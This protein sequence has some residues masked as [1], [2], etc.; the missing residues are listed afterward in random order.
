MSASETENGTDAAADERC[1]SCGIT[2]GDDVK[3]KNCNA[4]KLVKY[5][6][7]KCQ[8]DHRS[9]H[10]RACKK[11]AAEL[12]D[13]LLFKQPES[14]HLGDCPICVLPLP[15]LKAGVSYHMMACC[16]KLV[17][18]GC[19]Y[20]NG[21]REKRER[22]L[23]T[24]PFC[25]HQMPETVEKNLLLEM[26]RLKSNENDPIAL[27]KMGMRHFVAGDHA[28]AIECWEK[29]VGSGDIQSHYYLSDVYYCHN[30]RGVEQDMKK[31]MYHA[32]QAAIGGHPAARHNLGTWEEDIGKA[33]KHFIIAANLG[34]DDSL[35]EL[36]CFL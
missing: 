28:A 1:A 32:E 29:A 14:T 23:P 26:K 10:K 27:N 35:Q 19:M 8:R 5:C 12:K 33:A 24:C 2:G 13:E 9:Q 11:R 30:V 15:F 34:F 4:C 20:A 25:R 18:K 6:G 7:V 3:L 22:L 17:C 16:S 31:A 36:K 21:E